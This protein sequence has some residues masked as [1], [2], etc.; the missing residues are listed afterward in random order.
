MKDDGSPPLKAGACWIDDAFN[1]PTAH[2]TLDN[3]SDAYRLQTRRQ[4]GWV[5][6][7]ETVA[8]LLYVCLD[9]CTRD[10]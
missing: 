9:S 6:A 4:V 5:A 1:F 8:H 3:R 10:V 7:V 2:W